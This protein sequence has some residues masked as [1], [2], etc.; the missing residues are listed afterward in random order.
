MSRNTHRVL[1]LVISLATVTTMVWAGAG[2]TALLVVIPYGLWNYYDGW[3][4]RGWYSK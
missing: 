2:L 3:T 4:R 1:D